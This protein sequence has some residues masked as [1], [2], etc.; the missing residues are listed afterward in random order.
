MALSRNG[1]FVVA[2]G[3]HLTAGRFYDRAPA[4]VS[5]KVLDANASETNKDPGSFVISRL[6]KLNTTTRV[7]YSLGGTATSPFSIF[8][9]MIDYTGPVPAPPPIIGTG[10]SSGILHAGQGYVDIPPGQTDATVT[11]VPN[12][13]SRVEADESVIATLVTDPGYDVN[14][15]GP[16]AVVAIHDNDGAPGTTLNDSADAYV[17]DGTNATANFG[18]AKDLEVKKAGSGFNRVSYI[19]FDLSSV[20]AINS[21]KLNL[22]G[23]LSDTQDASLATSIFSVA[24]TS[25]TETGINFNNAPAA[26]ASALATATITGTTLQMVQFDVTAYVKA[27]FA[28][29]HKVV[30]FALKDAASSNSFV[31]FNSRE[32]G[33]QTPAL[34]VT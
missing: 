2:G 15:S 16:S 33:T 8:K 12:D 17:R 19:K 4:T 20:S 5:I 6:E 28:A 3:D 34:V 11:I 22:F 14:P 25:W 31:Q 13:D 21:V 30:S 24:D 29:G 23:K 18:T 26:G 7:Y 9:T 32:A 10:G 1:T 27:Q